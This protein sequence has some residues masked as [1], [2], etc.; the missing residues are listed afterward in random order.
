MFD[1][2]RWFSDHKVHKHQET[3]SRWLTD[4]ITHYWCSN[5]GLQSC[6]V[7]IHMTLFKA[8]FSST[9]SR[10]SK[11]QKP[12]NWKLFQSLA[13]I[14]TAHR[15]DFSVIRDKAVCS[16]IVCFCST[17]FIAAVTVYWT[18]FLS[19]LRANPAGVSLHCFRFESQC[20]LLGN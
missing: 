13:V 18:T 7:L 4:P 20:Q 9:M 1:G 16:V 15:P 12:P 10:I 14:Y 19:L 3:T 11:T 8:Y 6:W 2:Q 5:V 17:G